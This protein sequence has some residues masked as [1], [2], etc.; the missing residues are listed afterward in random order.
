MRT[1][2]RIKIYTQQT[3]KQTTATTT[4]TTTHHRQQ[5]RKTPNKLLTDKSAKLTS[6]RKPKCQSFPIHQ[7]QGSFHC[8]IEIALNSPS[9]EISDRNKKGKLITISCTFKN[10]TF[11]WFKQKKTTTTTFE[12]ERRR[13][14]QTTTTTNNN[15]ND[16][17]RKYEKEEETTAR[18]ALNDS[19]CFL[20]RFGRKQFVHKIQ[21]L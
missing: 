8:S 15:G 21:S 2:G 17:S 16:N 7:I 20:L 12:I 14:E 18:S 3:T 6:I 9:V 13:T 19:Q 4:T 1:F 5:E 10:R 11:R